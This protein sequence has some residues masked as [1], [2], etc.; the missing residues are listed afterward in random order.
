[1]CVCNTVFAGIYAVRKRRAGPTQMHQ[2]G[3]GGHA[4]W[5]GVLSQ[6]Q[7][8]LSAGVHQLLDVP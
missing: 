3:K 1:M 5:N 2:R 7:S 6:A 4:M 8:H